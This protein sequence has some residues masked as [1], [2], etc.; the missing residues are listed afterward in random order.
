M[1]GISGLVYQVVWLRLLIRAFG[2]TIYAVTTLVALFMAG[3]ALGSFLGARLS[4]RKDPL[5]T[6]AVMELV[7]GVSAVASTWI[8]ASLP[9]AFRL[10]VEVLGDSPSV[11]LLVRF[12]LAAL[13]L[14]PPT[15]LMGTTLPLLSAFLGRSDRG[16]TGR[17]YGANT[18]GAVLGVLMTGFVMIPVAGERAT[19]YVA[20]AINVVV[21]LA[22]WLWRDQLATPAVASSRDTP[23]EP[24]A[25]KAAR[26]GHARLILL[27]A[28][29]SGTCALALEVL[30]SR[31][32]TVLLGNS[33]Y[34][35][36][37]LLGAYLV[38]IG[39]GSTLV[40]SRIAKLRSPLAWLG[41]LEVGVGVLGAASVAT[42]LGLGLLERP[43]WKPSYAVLYGLDDFVWLA[44]EAVAIV[45][46]VT[47]LLG[48]IFPLACSLVEPDD[49]AIGGGVGRVYGVNTVG[50][51]LGSL[52]GGFVLIPLVGTGRSILLVSATSVAI[53]AAVLLRARRVEG[54]RVSWVLGP[55]VAAF[56]ALAIVTR[57][58]PFLRVLESKVNREGKNQVVFHQEDPGATVTVFETSRGGRILYVNGLY[59]SN[60]A[61]AVG[62]QMVNLP[63]A[64]HP[65]EGPKRVLTVGLGVGEALRHGIDVGH[66]VTVVELQPAVIRAFRALN[67]DA[68]DYLDHPRARIVIEDGRNF[69]LRDDAQYDLILVDG[70][71]PLYASGMAN[72][73]SREFAQLAKRHLTE[74]GVFV[75]WFPVICFERDFFT[76]YASM[77]ETFGSTAVFT[78]PLSSNAMILGSNAGLPLWPEQRDVFA[79]RYQRFLLSGEKVID[80][81]G[82]EVDQA[83]LIM[84]AR[85]ER[86]L[87]DDRPTTE[88]PLQGF[89]MGETYFLENRFLW[90]PASKP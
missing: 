54:V 50:G 48:A 46:P 18:L 36:S 33:I 55:G 23:S 32:L 41:A 81:A 42:F 60:T 21:G 59:T 52:L 66:S 83:D 27:V 84:R 16:A 26:G 11:L 89:L 61:P 74:R 67:R 4:A 25:P 62:Q 39:L 69:L 40:A 63:L 20:A 76:V 80:P 10:A 82:F 38:G 56:C 45:L 3:L 43:E 53:G 88:F 7:V 14:L 78:P 79:A 47:V 31:I 29:G 2:V 44:V 51:I 19:V 30:W 71:P 75:V 57:G 15:T 34:A 24:R 22:C 5:A 12:V 77:V 28:F 58:E 90:N 68:S 6:Y 86:P 13:V 8:M 9:D 85:R 49:D 70:S 65:D 37:S 35:F 87:S 1:T 64:F 73:Y 72:L 17:L